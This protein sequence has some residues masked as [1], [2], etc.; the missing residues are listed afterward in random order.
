MNRTINYNLSPVDVRIMQAIAA[1]K[2]GMLVLLDQR[3]INAAEKL[4]LA[5][6]LV[7]KPPG[8]SYALNWRGK[9]LY[10]KEPPTTTKDAT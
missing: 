3:E 10:G 5:G 4:A 8:P 6:L 2:R 9:K 7:R 1:S